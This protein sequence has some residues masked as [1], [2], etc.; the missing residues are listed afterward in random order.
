MTFND[1]GL[2][3]DGFEFNGSSSYISS[4]ILNGINKSNSFTCEIIFNAVTNND[5]ELLVSHVTSP[6]DV[7]G[8]S[9]KTGVLSTGM[10]NGSR[11][12]YCV[13]DTINTNKEYDVI[14]IFDGNSL[15]KYIYNEIVDGVICP[16]LDSQL[17]G[18]YI[19]GHPS[20]SE[21][22][23]SGTIKHV[24]IYNRA[25]TPQEVADRYN[26]VT[27]QFLNDTPTPT[28]QNYIDFLDNRKIGRQ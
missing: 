14:S 9:F 5:K 21:R 19:G 1:V 11:Y 22:C 28:Q 12:I 2:S 27:F 24:S 16:N 3:D 10:Y 18:L 25:L 8:T 7:F 4:N 6:N 15:T 23:F 20:A 26:E 17:I 13:S